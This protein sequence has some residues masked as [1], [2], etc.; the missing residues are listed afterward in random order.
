M[1]ILH[2]LRMGRKE[3]YKLLKRRTLCGLLALFRILVL[4]LG[5]IIRIKNVKATSIRANLKIKRLQT[6]LKREPA[7]F[8]TISFAYHVMKKRT[9]E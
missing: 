8:V 3:S 7:V 4:P 5:E 6:Q 1:P 9:M 2:V